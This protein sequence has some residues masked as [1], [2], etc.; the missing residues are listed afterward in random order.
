[1]SWT[2]ARRPPATAASRPARRRRTAT[3]RQVLVGPWALAVSALLMPAVHAE[4]YFLGE[5]PVGLEAD[6]VFGVEVPAEWPAE[7]QLRVLAGYQGEDHYGCFTVTRTGVQFAVVRAGERSEVGERGELP[8]AA[9]D[10]RVG[11]LR[12][13]QERA[14]WCQAARA[15]CQ[16]LLAVAADLQG[17]EHTLRQVAREEQRV[18]QVQTIIGR[19]PE[20]AVTVVAEVGEV[21]RFPSA[22]HLRSYAGLVPQV[23]QSGER[24]WID[25]LPHQGKPRLR[26][27]LVLA[28]QHLADNKQ[29]KGTHLK[30]RYRRRW[31]KHGPNPAKVAAARDPCDIIFALLLDGTWFVL[32]SL[33]A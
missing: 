31:T 13:R 14:E 11:V 20:P 28:A 16:V 22:A 32:E 30:Q 5:E 29:L 2:R 27:V 25:P 23:R 4:P 33:A 26:R 8:A 1:M 19:G 21:R 3:P 24:C 9:G 17:L 15:P 18:A 6:V 7:A 12:L 10:Y